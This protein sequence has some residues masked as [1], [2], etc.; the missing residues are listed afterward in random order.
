MNIR[1]TKQFF[2]EHGIVAVRADKSKSPEVEEQLVELGNTEKGIPYYAV[3]GPGINEP[4]TAEG[5]ITPGWVI[6]SVTKAMGENS[7][8][9]ETATRQ[10]AE[11]KKTR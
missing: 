6:E 11:A 3:Y 7:D 2:E 10:T 5:I 9:S 8:S 4:I 1:K